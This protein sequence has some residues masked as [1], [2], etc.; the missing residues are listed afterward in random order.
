MRGI[1]LSNKYE[2][3]YLIIKSLVD[4]DGNR[5][6]AA[7]KL[8]VSDRTVRRLIKGYREQGKE[9]FVH[10]NAYKRPSVTLSDELKSLVVDTYNSELYYGLNFK[11]FHEEFI[12]LYP[13]ISISLSSVRNVLNSYGIYSPKIWRST[14]KR[15]RAE[16]KLKTSGSGVVDDTE[17]LVSVVSDPH[18]HKPRKKFAGELIQMDASKHV[19]F[20]DSYSHLHACIDNATGTVTALYFDKEETLNGYFN[21]MAMMIRDYGIPYEILTDYRTVFAYHSA[22][23][24]NCV[25]DNG[26]DGLTN[27]T[28]AC[29]QLG[30]TVTAT[31]VAQKKGQIEKLFGTL[32]GRLPFFLKKKGVATIEEANAAIPEFLAKF[33]IQFALGINDSIS[34]FEKQVD[35]ELLGVTLATISTRKVDTGHGISYSNQKYLPMDKEGKCKFFKKGTLVNVVENYLGKMYISVG[36]EVYYAYQIPDYE[37]HS[38]SFDHMVKESP[39]KDL[40][41][42][43]PSKVKHWSLKSTNAFLPQMKVIL[44][45]WYDDYTSYL[46]DE[47][48]H[49][50]EV[51]QEEP[52]KPLNL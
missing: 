45:N 4:N 13:D 37:K 18:P 1:K 23:E 44:G 49:Y 50:H 29:K 8:G 14:K 40:R 16:E 10:G 35:E 3:Q 51:L 17:L 39:L 12:A 7:L 42:S 25:F 46:Y 15:L 33:N 41:E 20:G 28:Y 34:V 32:Q 30:T 22:R 52:Y 6:R 5:K 36:S 48:N 21:L 26:R 31:Y 27:F 43:I 9:F 2:S 47:V 38:E 24:S 19:W 11:F